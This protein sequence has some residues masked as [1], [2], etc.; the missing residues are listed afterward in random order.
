MA[1]YHQII[2]EYLARTG[3]IE[4]HVDAAGIVDSLCY[5]ALC[6]I[7]EILADPALSDPECFER[8]EKVVCILE[9]LG[10]DVGSRHDF[11]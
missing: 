5:Q 1:L 9:E 10:T 3:A 2:A 4:V 7:R 6:Q 8:I 11:G